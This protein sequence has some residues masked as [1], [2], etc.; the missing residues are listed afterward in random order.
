[1]GSP[2]ADN[3]RRLH[4]FHFCRHTPACQS[5]FHLMHF[6]KRLRKKFQIA[7]FGNLKVNS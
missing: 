4:F 6:I 2:A 1:M 5:F 7:S 3:N